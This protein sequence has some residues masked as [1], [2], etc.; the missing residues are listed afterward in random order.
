[1]FLTLLTPR[2]PTGQAPP[3]QTPARAARCRHN[4]AN[5]P[6]GPN[7]PAACTPPRGEGVGAACPALPPRDPAPWLRVPAALPSPPP[8]RRGGARVGVAAHF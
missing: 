7:A 8:A 1:M 5:G 4:G 2:L 6:N 3:P